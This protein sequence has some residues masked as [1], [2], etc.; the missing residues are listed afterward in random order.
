MTLVYLGVGWFLGLALGVA[1]PLRWPVWLTLSLLPVAAA[2]LQRHDRRLWR[3]FLALSFVFLGAARYSGRRP[4]FGPSDLASYN[5]Q[6][7]GEFEGYVAAEPDPG[8]ELTRL[9]VIVEQ[10]RLEGDSSRPVSGRVL[11]E[12]PRHPAFRYGERLEFSGR[13][14]TPPEGEGFSYRSY[15]ARQR[16]YSMMR[17]PVIRRLDGRN[18]SPV[19]RVLLDLKSHLQATLIRILPDPEAALLNGILLGSDQGI[20]TRI[21]DAFE[22]TGTSHIIAISGYNFSIITSMLFRRLKHWLPPRRAGAISIAVIIVYTLLVGAKS[23]VVRAAIMGGLIVVGDTLRRQT[24][25]PASLMAAGIGMTAVDP[26]VAGDVSFQLSF[27]ATCGLML[28]AEPLNDRTLT[29][30]NRVMNPQRAARLTGWLS[31][32]LLL[33]VAA[34]ITTLPLVVYYFGHLSSISLLTNLLVLPV[35]PLIMSLGGLTAIAGALFLPLG[36]ILA[37]FSFPF[38]WWTVRAVEMTARISGGSLEANLSLPGLVATYAVIAGLTWLAHRAR[39]LVGLRRRASPRL[40]LGASLGSAALALMLA[41]DLLH[42][43]PDGRLH[44]TFLDVGEGESVL[45]QT[46]SGRLIL[47]DGGPDPALLASHLGRELS[48]W[49][50]SLDL[51]I[52]THP[53]S[54]HVG[55]LPA[56]LASH[57][58]G[59]LLTNGQIDGPAAWVETLALAEQRAIPVV[60]AVRGQTVTTGD[61]VTLEVLHPTARLDEG[62]DDNSIVLQVQYHHATFLLTGDAGGDTEAALIAADLPLQSIV[63]KAADSG[64]RDGT[65]QPFLDAVDPWLVI[66]SVGKLGQNPNRHPADRVL[67]RVEEKGCEVGR[68]DLLGSIRLTTDGVQLWVANQS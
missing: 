46:P 59:A 60:T 1:C 55:G 16:I 7:W 19:K 31:D 24:F 63:L 18:G 64:D 51:V 12:A 37:W 20:S 53:D 23:G 58:I 17:Q 22:S 32:A 38:L 50:R 40:T 14:I 4:H 52:A 39:G 68:T 44:L 41:I 13:L 8:A 56:V 61:G 27:A 11:L 54:A 2:I 28:Y 65:T 49:R 57:Q 42:S 67:Q 48:F 5:D 34:Q 47:V 36:Q 26:L 9:T 45:I 29:A 30:L 43:L 35:Q 15:L 62:Y 6:R 21:A 33:S 66:F 3:P 25:A 10:M